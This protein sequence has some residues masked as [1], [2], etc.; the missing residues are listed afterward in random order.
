VLDVVARCQDFL[1]GRSLCRGCRGFCSW[2]PISALCLAAAD[3]RISGAPRIPWVAVDLGDPRMPWTFALYV[4][5]RV[6]P[7]RRGFVSRGLHAWQ[8]IKTV[9][10]HV[11]VPQ[12]FGVRLGCPRRCAL[13]LDCP[14]ASLPCSHSLA[15]DSRDT[16]SDFVT[17]GVTRNGNA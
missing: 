2:H 6:H 3:P 1:C 16:G 8:P 4:G 15:L 10:W 12:L 14:H 13:A 7:V 17:I 5:F 9:L 11:W